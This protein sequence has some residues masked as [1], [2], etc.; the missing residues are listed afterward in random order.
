METDAAEVAEAVEV[1]VWL[2]GD[3]AGETAGVE[4]EIADVPGMVIE[5]TE[6]VV[7]VEVLLGLGPGAVDVVAI[8]PI[9]VQDQVEDAEEAAGVQYHVDDVVDV[10][11]VEGQVELEKE[12]EEV[13]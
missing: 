13:V 10:V 4:N 3:V 12:L 8:E 1:V 11:D 6:K 5:G 9:D 2:V 7:V